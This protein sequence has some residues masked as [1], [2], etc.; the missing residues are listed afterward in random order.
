[1]SGDT[2]SS[3]S[4]DS[5]SGTGGQGTSEEVLKAL[6]SLNQKVDKLSEESVENKSSLEQLNSKIDS[7]TSSGGIGNIRI[8]NVLTGTAT[9]SGLKVEILEGAK[10]LIL[11]KAPNTGAS[12]DANDFG[13]EVQVFDSNNSALTGLSG[14]HVHGDLVLLP[15]G[16]SYVKVISAHQTVKFAYCFLMDN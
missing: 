11:G 10:A 13:L 9:A 8:S 4:S 3:S 5:G 14:W 7:L 12:G 16:S 6:E 15:G 1:M 2:I